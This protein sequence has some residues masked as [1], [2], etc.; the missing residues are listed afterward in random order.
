MALANGGVNGQTLTG[1][2]VVKRLAGQ[3]HVVIHALGILLCLPRILEEGERLEYVSLG[4]GN[5]GRNFDLETNA[6]IAEF[7]FI[8]WQGGPESV[9]QNSLFKDFF[10]LAEYEGSKR[11]YLYVL[12]TEYPLKFFNGNRALSSVL[13]HRD[14]QKQFHSKCGDAYWTVREYYTQRKHLVTI[15]DVSPWI[16]ELLEVEIQDQPDGE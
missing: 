1:A 7:K 4:A 13:T 9:R 11:R 10:F 2:G 14:V 8:S 6:R 3:I 5:T 15:E 12:G 16:P